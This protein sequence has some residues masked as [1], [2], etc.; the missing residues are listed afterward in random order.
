MKPI[1]K[2]TED[3][4]QPAEFLLDL[5]A[6]DAEEADLERIVGVCERLGLDET[7]YV[8]LGQP[9]ESVVDR[10]RRRL[11]RFFGYQLH[12]IDPQHWRVAVRWIPE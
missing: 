2:R 4:G 12:Q 3:E 1:L 7:L 9:P 11:P 8:Q 6:R 5:S 10:L